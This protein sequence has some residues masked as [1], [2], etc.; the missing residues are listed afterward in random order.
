MFIIAMRYAQLGNRLF[1]F[2]H[3]IA[4]AIENKVKVMN[5]A[6]FEYAD[7]FKTT[8]KDFFCRYPPKKSLLKGNKV[9]SI[10]F[11]YITF[12]I[13]TA[14]LVLSHI[15][16]NIF[17]K[18][19]YLP[20][21]CG[22]MAELRLDYPDFFNFIRPKQTIFLMGWRFRDRTN[23]IK[24]ADKIRAYFRPREQYMSNVT[25]LISKSRKTCDILV[26]VHIRQGD[27]KNPKSFG[28]NMGWHYETDTYIKIMEKIEKLFQGKKVGFLISSDEKQDGGK[29][30]KFNFTF[31][32]GHVIEDMYSLAQCDYITGPPSTY[33]GWAS[34]YG[35]V[36]QYVI[37]DPDATISLEKFKRTAW[38]EQI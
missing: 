28:H 20:S 5:P 30:S 34:F 31:G 16:K 4:C 19:I 15:V 32:T 35:D 23:I 36:P 3:I 25:A 21:R 6:F 8:S 11:Y 27:V 7:F 1:L 13:S 10:P 38:R 12:F 33:S 22:A 9:L 26:G 18:T 2:A 17:I 24:H 37:F 14:I 29:F